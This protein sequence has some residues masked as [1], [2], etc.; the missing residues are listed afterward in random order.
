MSLNLTKLPAGW[1]TDLDCQ[2]LYDAAVNAPLGNFCEIGV[3]QGRSATVLHQAD[4]EREL[5]LFDAMVDCA[6]KP[7][8]W[9]HGP[10]V[11]HVLRGVEPDD[12]KRIGNIAVLHIDGN[13][14]T[15][16]VLHDLNCLGPSVVVGGRIVLHDWDH[17][18]ASDRVGGGVCTAWSQWPV[19]DSFETI[20]TERDQAGFRRVK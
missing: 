11:H 14:T 12:A 8:S 3:Y 19:H 9:P 1:F 5:W 16:G 7:E 10:R 6:V 13:H 15:T 2:R 18:N 4:P 17:P 20:F